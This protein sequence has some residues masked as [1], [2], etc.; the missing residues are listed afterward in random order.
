MGIDGAVGQGQ[1]TA[2]ELFHAQATAIEPALAEGILQPARQTAIF[3]QAGQ[4]SLPGLDPATGQQRRQQGGIG[5]G[6]DVE[7]GGAVVDAQVAVLAG[8]ARGGAAPGS[9]AA[10]PQANA[11]RWPTLAPQAGHQGTAADT[12]S[13]HG[14]VGCIGPGPGQAAHQNPW[15]HPSLTQGQAVGSKLIEIPCRSGRFP[16]PRDIC[17]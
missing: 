7:Q 12:G 8:A 4:G 5:A 10:F 16:G 3:V 17:Y 6:A 13:D 15:D 14:E 1:Q 2:A 9:A 11:I